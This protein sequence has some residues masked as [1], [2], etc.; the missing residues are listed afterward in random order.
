[1]DSSQLP[2]CHQVFGQIR[3]STLE[4]PSSIAYHYLTM[5]ER[6]RPTF[7]SSQQ[8]NNSPPYS[9]SQSQS[10]SCSNSTFDSSKSSEAGDII[11]ENS[12]ARLFRTLLR[13]LHFKIDSY[14]NSIDAKLD[15]ILKCLAPKIKKDKC[16]GTDK[17]N[18]D[19]DSMDDEVLTQG[20]NDVN[21]IN[22]EAPIQG[23]QKT[24]E[25][26]VD[27]INSQIQ[28]INQI[29]PIDRIERINQIEPI[30]QTEES[31]LIGNEIETIGAGTIDH[32][33]PFFS[34]PSSLTSE[35]GQHFALS[36]PPPNTPEV[37]SEIGKILAML[38]ST[39]DG[40]DG[41]GSFQL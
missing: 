1:M 31:N 22:Y 37:S 18:E 6:N 41:S 9:Q 19:D 11:D 20:T 5:Q 17:D 30:D 34:P 16:G 8:P 10:P 28:Q 32:S 3:G 13:E 23:T 25:N 29:E 15:L 14:Q 12:C 4:N 27:G 7:T 26:T 35:I 36:P 21:Y 24:G 40:C 33:T 2:D 39:F 38:S